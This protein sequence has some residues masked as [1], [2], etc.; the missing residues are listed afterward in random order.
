MSILGGGGRYKTRAWQAQ[1]E[2]NRIAD[3]EAEQEFKQGILSNIRQARIARSQ[4][5]MSSMFAEGVSISGVEG[6]LANI[7]SVTAGV[8]GRAYEQK[9]NVDAYQAQVKAA[10]LAWKKYA[11]HQK[12]KATTVGAVTAVVGAVIGGV[13]GGPAGAVIGA[14]TGFK[15]GGAAA[16]KDWGGTFSALMQGASSAVTMG[17]STGTDSFQMTQQ[18]SM[19]MNTQSF[20][21]NVGRKP[22]F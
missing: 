14:Q 4:Q 22:T 6:G 21:K 9:E 20:A 2:A 18:K 7:S 11:K 16:N 3:Y 8:T 15:A 19:G 1:A 13:T 12:A 5:E 17:G 10:E